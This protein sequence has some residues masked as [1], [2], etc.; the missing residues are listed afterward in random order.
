MDWEIFSGVINIIIIDLVL[1]GDNAVVIAMACMGLPDMYRRKAIFWGVALA[2]MLRVTL[3]FI[4]ALL[5]NIP[6]V[7]LGGGLLL[8][9]IA[10][11]LLFPQKDHG[12]DMRDTCESDF[13]KAILTIL[14][15]DV[16]MSLDNVLAVAGASGGNLFLLIFGIALSIPIVLAG[17]T[18]LTKLMQKF[19]WLIYVGAGVLAW[20]AGKMIVAD[21]MVSPYLHRIIFGEVAVPLAI[22]AIV[23]FIGWRVRNVTRAE[24]F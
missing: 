8:S 24:S 2:V 1:S 7:Q 17:S 11:K 13:K 6:L 20:T 19:Q 21:K 14:W 16:I 12:V 18:L 15:A 3:T 23:I 5:L 22:T 4:A 9:W 10:V